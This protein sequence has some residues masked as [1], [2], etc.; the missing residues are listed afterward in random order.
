MEEVSGYFV[1]SSRQ[2]FLEG[3]QILQSADQIAQGKLAFGSYSAELSENARRLLNGT[4]G[5]MTGTEAGYAGNW[6]A[7]R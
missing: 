4:W 1:A 7:Q 2:V 3:R 6:E 5:S